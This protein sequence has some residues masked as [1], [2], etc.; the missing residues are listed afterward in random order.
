MGKFILPWRLAIRFRVPVT[1][2]VFVV[3]SAA[4]HAQG[5]AALPDPDTLRGSSDPLAPALT[6]PTGAYDPYTGS[7]QVGFGVGIGEMSVPIAYSRGRAYPAQYI[8]N[9]GLPDGPLGRLFPVLPGGAIVQRRPYVHPPADDPGGRGAY[10]ARIGYVD[11][12]G[13]FTECVRDYLFQRF[14]DPNHTGRTEAHFLCPSFDR[15]QREL[16][17]DEFDYTGARVFR[18]APDGSRVTYRAVWRTQHGNEQNR[19]WFLPT[20]IESPIGDVL[21][22]EY[23]RPDTLQEVPLPQAYPCATDCPTEDRRFLSSITDRY[24]RSLRFHYEQV[25]LG[26]PRLTRITFDGKDLARFTP[27]VWTATQPF[28]QFVYLAGH[29]TPEGHETRFSMTGMTVGG[30]EAEPIL[31]R[32]DLPTGGSVVF[33]WAFQNFVRCDHQPQY[34]PN[35]FGIT[36]WEAYPRLTRIAHGGET[37]SISYFQGNGQ[38]VTAPEGWPED[39]TVGD[40]SFSSQPS[41]T[42]LGVYVEAETDPYRELT[43]FYQNSAGVATS[44]PPECFLPGGDCDGIE[45]C[46]SNPFESRLGFLQQAG[47]P[48]RRLE[49]YGETPVSAKRESW[50]YQLARLNASGFADAPSNTHSLTY[51]VGTRRYESQVSNADGSP[52]ARFATELT[53]DPDFALPSGGPQQASSVLAQPIRIERFAEDDPMARRHVQTFTYRSQGPVGFGITAQ[54]WREHYDIGLTTGREDRFEDQGGGTETLFRS[55]ICHDRLPASSD[56]ACVI[57]Q[58]CLALPTRSIHFRSCPSSGCPSAAD[59]CTNPELLDDAVVRSFT[60]HPHGSGASSNRLY[61]DAWGLGSDQVATYHEHYRYGVPTTLRLPAGPPTTRVINRDGTL[62][63]ETAGG[64]KIDLEYDDDRR[65]IVRRFPLDEPEVTDL[66]AAGVFPRQITV[67][68]GTDPW[69]E[70]Q[71]LD[72]WGRTVT[73][74]RRIDGDLTGVSTQRFAPIGL[75]IE[76]IAPAPSQAASN[77]AIVVTAHDVLGR[78]VCVTTYAADAPEPRVACSPVGSG[79]PSAAKQLGYVENTYLTRPDGTSEVVIAQRLEDGDG[80]VHT[81]R[82]RHDLLGRLTYAETNSRNL[83]WTDVTHTTDVLDGRTRRLRIIE[84]HSLHG[85]VMANL[86]MRKIWTDWLGNTVQTEDPETG[87][88][89][90]AYD[91]LNR[92]AIQEQES[93]RR[94]GF[95]YDGLGRVLNETYCAPGATCGDDPAAWDRLTSFTYASTYNVLERAESHDNGTVVSGSS[96]DLQGRPLRETVAFPEPPSGPAGLTPDGSHTL[97]GQATLPLTWAPGPVGT[98]FQ[99]QLLSGEDVIWRGPRVTGGS[100]D[101]PTSLLT[102]GEVYAWRVRG[103]DPADNV[104]SLWSRATLDLRPE[105]EP[106]PVLEVRFDGAVVADGASVAFP[107]TEAGTTSTLTFDVANAATEGPDLTVDVTVAGDPAFGPPAQQI[108]ALSPGSA[109]PVAFVFAPDAA[110]PAGSLSG[111]V[112]FTGADQTVTLQLTGE[113]FVSDPE[114]DPNPLLTCDDAACPASPATAGFGPVVVGQVDGPMILRITN[115]GGGTLSGDVSVT[116]DPRADGTPIFRVGGGTSYALTAGETAAFPV[117]FAPDTVGAWTG[118]VALGRSDGS[119]REHGVIALAGSAIDRSLVL[120]VDGQEVEPDGTVSFRETVLNTTACRT[121]RVSNLGG[122]PVSGNFAVHQLTDPFSPGSGNPSSHFELAPQASVAYEA[123]FS[124]GMLSQVRTRLLQL[125]NTSP[126]DAHVYTFTL[127]GS[128]VPGGVGRLAWDRARLDFHDVTAGATAEREVRFWNVSGDPRTAPIQV[129]LESFY[130]EGA[131]EHN[132]SLVD[133]SDATHDNYLECTVVS[134]QDGDP[135]TPEPPPSLGNYYCWTRIAFHPM[136]GD[137]PG[138]QNATLVLTYH[139]N[140]E[141]VRLDLTGEVH[142]RGIGVSFSG[143]LDPGR[144]GERDFL[145]VEVTNHF[146]EAAAIQLWGTGFLEASLNESFADGEAIFPRNLVVPSHGTG[147]GAVFNYNPIEEPV[148]SGEICWRAV[149]AADPSRVLTAA[150]ECHA[151]QREVRFGIEFGFMEAGPQGMTN[152][153]LPLFFG[154]G[155]SYVDTAVGNR[156]PVPGMADRVFAINQSCGAESATVVLPEG[157]TFGDGTSSRQIDLPAPT[158][159]G[160]GDWLETH[161]WQKVPVYFSPTRAGVMTGEMRLVPLTNDL[162]ETTTRLMGRGIRPDLIAT[163]PSNFQSP[164]TAAGGIGELEVSLRASEGPP[165]T[166]TVDF[167]GTHFGRIVLDPP[168][169]CEGGFIGPGCDPSTW[170]ET[171]DPSPFQMAVSSAGPATIRIGYRPDDP[172]SDVAETISVR[173]EDETWDEA[174]LLRGHGASEPPGVS[175]GAGD[176]ASAASGDVFILER[177]FAGAEHAYDFNFDNGNALTGVETV[178]PVDTE[179]TRSITVENRGSGSLI[180]RLEADAPFCL[181][182]GRDTHE[183]LPGQSASVGFCVHLPDY[184]RESGYTLAPMTPATYALPTE[185]PDWVSSLVQLPSEKYLRFFVDGVERHRMRLFAV[186]SEADGGG[187]ITVR[188]AQTDRTA[189]STNP[190]LTGG[191]VGLRTPVARSHHF[192]EVDVGTSEGLELYLMLGWDNPEELYGTVEIIGPD[193]DSFQWAEA[194]Y[195]DAASQAPGL[196]LRRA[197]HQSPIPH[198][199]V[200]TPQHDGAHEATLVFNQ[201]AGAGAGVPAVDC[202]HPASLDGCHTMTITGTGRLP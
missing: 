83:G 2:A 98:A 201:H 161:T 7:L 166:V 102:E 49:L 163:S 57:G 155:F 47:K 95:V 120:T 4:A 121:L 199:I 40:V 78:P 122:D 177:F 53:Y 85:F 130:K 117:T 74:E 139:P 164:L 133:T 116:S 123:C 109:S 138:E 86:P 125:R 178:V 10:A 99:V 170:P 160:D 63:S 108:A 52:S 183:V 147:N 119:G 191:G 180:F 69:L 174:L 36:T 187:A 51:W 25:L 140:R 115:I 62:K 33:T 146:P 143:G 73:T 55:A 1:L 94:Y 153:L 18:L 118:E 29:E 80:G 195:R 184:S 92:L 89:R 179:L 169:G 136:A 200:F 38:G 50:E 154:R 148:V 5:P 76:A 70:Q 17:A 176:W 132:F 114:A 23:L 128:G 202:R 111:T 167:A 157:W 27:A 26:T 42:E 19:M 15:I 131:H 158:V 144:V 182:E 41:L 67:G 88:V 13:G 14:D 71:T 56:G 90:I 105:A 152:G 194:E 91:A 97:D 35:R 30:Y 156:S 16:L 103:W 61:G 12:S 165:R 198:R 34:R 21:T 185:H 64:V 32:I 60:Y 145:S 181:P 66:G 31:R 37:Y 6:F 45:F 159:C 22:L 87:I 186:T 173:S 39:V 96:F 126:G 58:G 104:P 112:T 9:T 172:A 72:P 127:E 59:A 65:P 107:V 137:A 68:R 44:P 8:A 75:E 77:G 142:A 162:P 193:A 197:E 3:L 196:R 93:G 84:P 11:A 124:P 43:F 175:D 151:F 28:R 79:L 188:E 135:S 141:P 192:G 54:N 190:R 129:G 106:E 168:D 20:E 113:V 171:L 134:D 101:L 100:I 110:T 46:S 81:V 82:T 189:W 150:D 24:G 149:A 48:M